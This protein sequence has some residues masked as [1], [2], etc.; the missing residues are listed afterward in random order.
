MNAGRVIGAGIVGGLVMF[1]W[2]FVSHM[3]IPINDMGLDALPNES[4]VVPQLS[5]SIQ[6]RNFYIF[7]GLEKAEMSDEAMKEWSARYEK[8]P[9]GILVFDP[10]ANVG[11]MSPTMLGTECASNIGAALLA[12]IVLAHVGGTRR[13]RVA[14]AFLIGV[15]GWLSIDVSYWNWWRFPDMYALSQLIDQ[16]VG[17]LL[18]GIAIVLVLGRMSAPRNAK[19]GEH[20]S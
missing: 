17:W 13:R 4:V 19:S 18:S 20:P 15:I 14:L 12:A 9:R 5:A 16:G 3:L 10:T 7:P 8:G 11:A 1:F 6:E 2:G